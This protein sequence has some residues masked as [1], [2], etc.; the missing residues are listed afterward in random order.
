MKYA[1]E[2]RLVG[3]LTKYKE[4]NLYK[5]TYSPNGL[6]RLE[7]KINIPYKKKGTEEWINSFFFLK[8][9]GQAGEPI[10]SC[11]D[12]DLVESKGY[13][14]KYTIQGKDGKTIYREEIIA[15]NITKV[16]ATVPA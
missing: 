3:K 6:A 1:N 13:F 7:Y 4:G 14:R 16:E 8:A 2:V 11:Q 5:E 15:V 10:K 9:W 12:G